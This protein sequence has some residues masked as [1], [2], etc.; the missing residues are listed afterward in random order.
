MRLR[1]I[2]FILIF[3]LFIMPFSLVLM[4]SASADTDEEAATVPVGEKMVTSQAAIVMDHHT[5]LVIFEYNADDMRVPAS[6]VKMFAVYVI[7]DTIRDGHISY[8]AFIQTSAQVS[9]FSFNRE[10]SNV[11]MPVNSFFTVRSLLDAVI[12]RS[13][14]AAT[15]ALGEGIF[16]SEEVLVYKMN[17][18]AEQLGIEA[19][20]FDSWGGSP[21]NRLSARG[22]ADLT[23]SLINEHPAVLGFTSQSSIFFDEIEYRN[24]NPLLIDYEGV[25]GFKTGY[26]NAAGWCF[27]GTAKINGRR[28]I[29]VTMGSV[30]G[31]RF[32]D[33]VIL[34]DHGFAS[35]DR[36]MADHFRNAS[37]PNGFDQKANSPLV[38]IVLYNVKEVKHFDLIYL[39]M[40]L[41]EF[42][43]FTRS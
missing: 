26:T 36:V 14:C 11:P 24:T 40:I 25:D 27:T 38:P 21:E 18:K 5:G 3:F 34:L 35:F 42:N 12:V 15:V 33:T 7:L 8:E 4:P 32:P 17:E 43:A 41:N 28:L 6:M 19:E 29:S 9:A 37:K 20:F 2:F 39:A 13:A 10:Y 31:Y 30:Q 23:R 16:G 1:K 22:M